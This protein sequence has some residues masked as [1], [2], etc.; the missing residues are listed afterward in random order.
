MY[1]NYGEILRQ[2]HAAFDDAGIIVYQAFQPE[3][4]LEAVRLQ[5]FGKG[6]G[7]DRMTWIKPSFGWMLYRCG[8]ASKPR[9]QRIAQVTISHEGFHAMLAD[10]VPS[11]YE[12]E[13]FASKSD[14][15]V[16]LRRG[17]ARY[18]WD[19]DRDLALRPLERRA[20]QLGI[21][22]DLIRRYAREWIVRIADVTELAHQVRDAIAAGQAPPAVPLEQVYPLPPELAQRLHISA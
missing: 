16:A 4:V 18:Q 20:L 7:L 13:L 6:F 22:G 10:A 15:D 1:S 9:Q 21:Q 2:V 8:Y 3:T 17:Q 12:R 11:S 14:W 5:A 19:P